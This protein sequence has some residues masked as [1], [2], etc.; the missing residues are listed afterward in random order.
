MCNIEEKAEELMKE[1]ECFLNKHDKDPKKT[2]FH[3]TNFVGLKGILQTRRL[4]LT[5]HKYLN[6]P[7]EI[8]HGKNNILN[9]IE[10]NITH[11]SN[12]QGFLKKTLA[13]IID[14]GYK[15]FL[16]SFCQRE[17]Y[18]PAWRYY[19]DNGA[20]FAIGFNKK[21]FLR[22]DPSENIDKR[23][24]TLLFR[25]SYSGSETFTQFDDI[26]KIADEIFPDWKT[27]D[28]RTLHHY[29][30]ALTSGLLPILPR[31]KHTDYQDEHEWR[32]CIIRIYFEKENQWYPTELPMDRFFIHELV[33]PSIPP[34]C[35]KY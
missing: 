16:T 20:G 9:Y 26:F 34:I 6:D 30:V 12:L 8:A 7:S 33:N 31:V 10:K 2:L 25:V 13:D 32:L 18:L 3:Y 29:L 24:A 17:D 11:N 14:Q 1:L 21:Y 35:K 27:K 28:F 15:T 5:D 22:S 4:W 23:D 19:G